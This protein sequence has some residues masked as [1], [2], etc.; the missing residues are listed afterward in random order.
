[1]AVELESRYNHSDTETKWYSRWEQ[2]NIFSPDFDPEAHFDE[3]FSI[4]IPPPNVTGQLHV[5]HALDM[6]IQD[7]LI[8][9]ARKRGKRTLWLPGT[10]HA[11]IATQSRVEKTLLEEE[12][13]TK[14]D[15][16]RDKFVERVWEWKQHYGGLIT[17]QMRKLGLSVDWSRERF[18]MD[19]GLSRAVRKVFV[20]LYHEGLVYR[21]TRLINWDPVTHTVL[22]D[23]EVEH[24]ENF[25]SEL[26]SFA[27][28][29]KEGGEIV[30][31]T[32]RPETMLGD[33]AIAVHPEDPRYKK[34][35]G[36]TVK[37]PLLDREIPIIGD[38]ILVDPEFGTGAVKV[39]PA[40]D[41][42]D[43]DVGKRHDLE[44]I[45]IFDEKA[46]INENGGEFQGLDRFDARKAI[47]KAIGDLGL[48]RG[49]KEHMMAIGRS[50]RSGAIVEAMISTQW[51]IKIKP[52]A[53]PA[54]KAVETG[55]IRIIPSQWENTY[56]N[57][58]REIRDWCISRQLWWGH[59]IPAFHCKTCGHITVSIEDPDVCESCRSDDIEQDPDVLDTWFSSGLW[60]FST[61]GWPEKTDD[62]RHYY[63]TSVLVTGFDILFFWVAR[64]IMFGL[65]FMKERPFKDVYIHGLMR[66]EKG[67]K[68]SK[69][70]GNNIDPVDVINNYGADAYRFFLMA[71]LTEGKD[72]T[73]SESRLK[74]YQN[75][76][77]K[78]WNSSR[79]VLMNLPD[80]F[81]PKFDPKST[82]LEAEDHWILLQLNRAITEM[83]QTLDSYRFHITTETIYTF[84]WNFYCDW[85]IE[86]IKPR[87]Y[88]KAGEASCEAARQTAF[89]VLSA[90]L[91]LL[92]PFMPFITEEIN[93]HLKTFRK[94]GKKNDSDDMKQ[95]IVV[96]PWPTVVKLSKKSIEQAE[97]LSLLQ[98]VIGAIRTIR[99]EAGIAPDKKVKVIVRSD[100][101]PLA[102]F[103]AAKEISILRLAQAESIEV[104]KSH[105]S[106]KYDSMEPFSGG[107]V[108]LPLE[109]LLD[110]E[111]E[112]QRLSDDA[113]KLSQKIDGI[114]KKLSNEQFVNNAPA[115]VVEKEKQKIA[116]M[117]EKHAALQKALKRFA[118]G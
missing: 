39:T 41:P 33:T 19:E 71:T 6:T 10:D 100:S 4:V 65:H 36:K 50:Q 115:D 57:W 23:L 70:L 13:V 80:D 16:G 74:G 5:G 60:P 14:Y 28:P 49:A 90:M 99:A 54:I 75:F 102:G 83:E 56:F 37:H 20:D 105:K 58:M 51:F 9:A 91:D 35:I 95:S 11:G 31:A 17:S 77:N 109:G 40:H 116:E 88:G 97:G 73:Y 104:A 55:E 34:L 43:F 101:K 25:K 94:S 89:Y 85:Y 48:D 92:N 46:A 82:D 7:V 27:Y 107:E 52:L 62:L 47:K 2:S 59:R 93:S 44:F 112:K 1:M 24:E 111:K 45:S 106:G 110:I 79:F 118:G 84:V 114:R 12:G 86:L 64:M 96:S 108:Y 103:I 42:N 78:V 76:A 15:V 117:E 18:T 21:D 72:S 66:D 98:E 26:W 30:V 69:S 61:M 67:R 87:L 8:R 29:L 22:S 38:A 53:E 68:I 81:V 63:P 3:T 32:T 113:N